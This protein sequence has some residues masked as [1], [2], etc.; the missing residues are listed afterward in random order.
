MFTECSGKGDRAH[1]QHPPGPQ[2]DP[3]F[4]SASAARNATPVTQL[5]SKGVLLSIQCSPYDRDCVT[6][7][8]QTYMVW[9]VVLTVRSMQGTSKR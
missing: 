8:V 4:G 7:L 9:D 6:Q 5:R 3:T 1:W 2:P